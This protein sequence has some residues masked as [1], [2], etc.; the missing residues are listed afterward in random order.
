VAEAAP[1]KVAQLVYL[2]AFVPL[3]NEPMMAANAELNRASALN[4]MLQPTADGLG[5][6]VADEAIIPAF[7]HDCSARDV[8]FAKSRLVAQ[9]VE[10]LNAA[11]ELTAE[12]F[13]TVP[14]AFIECIED[15]AIHIASQRA[16]YRRAGIDNIATLNTGHSP[17]FSAPQQL[18]EAI[19]AVLN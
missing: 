2:C 8:A 4:G 11:V 18:A 16:L 15:Q 6:L 19:E 17:F 3:H 9:A 12:R 7:Y 14:K 5:I 10:P 13:G 1:E